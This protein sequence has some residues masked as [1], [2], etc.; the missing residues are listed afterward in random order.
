MVLFSLFL[1]GSAL[2]S[3]KK[4]VFNT[5]LLIIIGFWS[6]KGFSRL[7]LSESDN[8]LNHFLC[9]NMFYIQYSCTFLF[10][11]CSGMDLGLFIFFANVMVM[12]LVISLSADYQQTGSH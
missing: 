9:E 3:L 2:L 4:R 5:G 8:H 6:W 12:L 11:L 7:L 1:S 10:A